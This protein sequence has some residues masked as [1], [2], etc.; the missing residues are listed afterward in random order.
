MKRSPMLAA[1]AL[2]ALWLPGSSVAAVDFVRD[3]EPILHQRCY[4]CHGSQQQMSDL[5][6]DSR[7]AALKGGVSGRV[8]EPGAP[9]ASKLIARISSPDD[10]FRMPPGGD[11]LSVSDRAILRDWIAAGAPWPDSHASSGVSAVQGE[12]AAT[13]HWAFRPV[14]RPELPAVERSGW[15]RNPIDRFILRKLEAEGLEP[16]PEAARHTLL[17]RVHFDLVGLPPTSG[18]FNA[19][20]DGG[21]PGAYED[22]VDSLLQSRHF[23]E[24]WALPWLDLARYADSEGYERD[25]LRPHAWRWRHWLID[26]INRD[27]PYDRFTIEQIA[28]DLLPGATLEQRVATGFLRNGI[29]NREA[30]TKNAQKRFEET[31]DRLNTVANTWLGLTVGCAQCHDHKYDPVSQREF[32]A[33][34]AFFHNAVERDLEAPLPGELGPYLRTAPAFRLGVAQVREKH[35]IPALQATW[36]KRM[37]A[38]IDQPGL[39]TDWD[40]S[41]TEWRAANDRADWLLR[42]PEEH[43]TELERQRVADWFL[44][45]SGPD[46]AKDEVVAA[47][48]K[49]A[50]EEVSALR[51]GFFDVSRA[52][53]MV[54]RREPVPA[55]LALRGDYRALGSEV[56]PGVPAMLP[57]LPSASKPPRLLLAEWVA[58]K[59]NPLTARVEVNRIWHELFGRGLVETAEN[60]GTQ[61][62]APSHPALL[63]WLADEFVRLGWSRKALVRL[64]VTS[65]TYRQSSKDRE[66]ARARDPGNAWFARQNRL[67][68]P[69]ELIRDNILASSGLLHPKVGGKSVFPP[70]PGGISELSYSKKEWDEDTGPDRYRRGL[71]VFLRRTSPYPML[72]NFDAPDTLTSVSRRERSNTPLQAL[73]LLND[74][75]FLEAADALAYSVLQNRELDFQARFERLVL[76]C[77]T[78]LPSTEERELAK[79]FYDAQLERFEARGADAERSAWRE[80]SRAVLSL[81]EFITRE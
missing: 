30:G 17:R 51:N 37:L 77:L 66:N 61:G 74:P 70:Q 57:A 25:P 56:E 59:A 44:L 49:K 76:Q 71:Y 1:S 54:E 38:A 16:S 42:A 47:R 18:E 15:A 65:A 41:V 43:L 67:R 20:L 46:F 14:A 62:D 40:H 12:A 72:V 9:D 5:R 7:E 24:R 60:F 58:S 8:I 50:R 19:F 27:M 69:A 35:G 13:S 4:L 63:D 75:A 45:R 11:A 6:L 21:T 81:D 80:L 39:R 53:T 73:N 22:V 79:R 28:G 68:L 32:Y 29:K 48:L 52:Y 10:G 64:I 34:F 36:R 78:R 55:R 26:A 3:V 2:W 23:G 33:L 31:V